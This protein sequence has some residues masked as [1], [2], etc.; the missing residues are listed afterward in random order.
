MGCCASKELAADDDPSVTTKGGKAYTRVD[1]MDAPAKQEEAV[2]EP[3]AEAAM[4]VVVRAKGAVARAA[5][6]SV[7]RVA[8]ED[9]CLLI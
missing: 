3:E 4:V 8:M 5:V 1:A 7:V 9:S 2:V 6:A